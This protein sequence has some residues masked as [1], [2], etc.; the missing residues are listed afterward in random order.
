[1]GNFGLLDFLSNS[2]KNQYQ[3]LL[4]K[5]NASQ[6]YKPT[7]RQA[8]PETTSTPLN[9]DSY[10]PS[11]DA[12]AQAA[13]Q[14]KPA[15]TAPV[16]TED[17]KPE[18]SAEVNPDAAPEDAP[19][20]PAM[21]PDGTYSF[22]RMSRLDYSMD[23]RFNL[24]TFTQTVESIANG[25]V[26][27]L[28]EFA[29]AGFG[30]SADLN[31]K[32]SQAI[33]TNSDSAPNERSTMVNKSFGRAGMAQK[34]A[35]NSRN[36]ALNSFYKEAT[37]IGR[38]SKVID[39]GT[40]R[41][42]I[43]KIGLRYKLDSNFSFSFLNK[44]NVQTEQMALRSPEAVNNY[45][46]SAGNVAESGTSEMMASFFG[47]V[48]GYLNQAEQDL[49]NRAGEFFDLAT[50]ELGFSGEI[51]QFAKENFV[52]TISGFFDRVDTAIAELSSQY[53]PQVGF[54]TPVTES[55]AEVPIPKDD[56][57]PAVQSDA[58]QLATA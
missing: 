16:A 22:E 49:I 52:A 44:F 23:L 40:H 35:A 10:T 46:S 53:A 4:N 33:V 42:T 48:D 56:F 31:F 5:I 38:S 13:Q 1:M 43:N 54:S 2:F 32:G 21:M 7:L 58:T 19:V 27:S 17:V 6:N 8:E 30:L 34:F 9:S 37:Q 41:M 15:T 47:A 3:N 51:V 39:N 11:P 45:I 36:F 55:A 26:Q 57:N 14:E 18:D 24:S 12:L 50:E 29:F 20:N 28:E 25:E